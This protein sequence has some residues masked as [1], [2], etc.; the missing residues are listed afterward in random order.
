MT[1]VCGN[2]ATARRYRA[3]C[4]GDGAAFRGNG[5][6]GRRNGATFRVDGTAR[7]GYRTTIRGDRAATGS[8]RATSRRDRTA[9]GS[10]SAAG[11][12]DGSGKDFVGLT[13]TTNDV[14]IEFANWILRK[15]APELGVKTLH[16]VVAAPSAHNFRDGRN[17]VFQI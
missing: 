5:A 3:A 10:N 9:T 2:C 13:A 7:C 15:P 14:E 11:R 1:A 16:I 4:C 6:A 8:H 12:G 17:Y